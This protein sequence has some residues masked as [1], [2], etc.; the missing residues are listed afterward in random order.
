M[1]ENAEAKMKPMTKVSAT[2]SGRPAWG[3]QSVNGATP[4]IEA[5]MT[6]FRPMRSPTGPPIIVP[7]ATAA[8]KMNRRNCEVFTETWKRSMR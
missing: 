1:A 8:R 6:R 4:R 7:S 2:V 5:Q 3:S